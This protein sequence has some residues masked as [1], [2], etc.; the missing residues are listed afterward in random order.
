MRVNELVMF[1][2]QQHSALVCVCYARSMND[3]EAA[4][5]IGIAYGFLNC[6]L[7]CRLIRKVF[8]SIRFLWRARAIDKDYCFFMFW[9]T[10]QEQY[11][12]G[13]SITA[14]PANIHLVRPWNKSQRKDEEKQIFII[15]KNEIKRMRNFKRS[16]DVRRVLR[17]P[18]FAAADDLSSRMRTDRNEMFWVLSLKFTLA[19]NVCLRL[20]NEFDADEHGCA[21]AHRFNTWNW[22]LFIR[23]FKKCSAWPFVRP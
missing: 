18:S 17:L 11:A 2:N 7:L 12:L 14:S 9:F 20:E 1:L 3:D 19:T 4:A 22:C 10:P 6:I 16:H 21:R 13:I 23:P 8:S 15:V 5:T